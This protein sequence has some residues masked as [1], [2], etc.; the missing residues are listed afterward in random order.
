MAPKK[1]RKKTI[2]KK[3][4]KSY[5]LDRDD[6]RQVGQLCV[7]FFQKYCI[8]LHCIVEFNSK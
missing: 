7:L 3:K 4:M 6:N 8:T 2:K 1:K 5:T